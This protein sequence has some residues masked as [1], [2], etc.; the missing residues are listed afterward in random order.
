MQ[1]TLSK[2]YSPIRQAITAN[3]RLDEKSAVGF[4]SESKISVKSTALQRT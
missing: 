2:Q 3:Y 4:Q 1:F